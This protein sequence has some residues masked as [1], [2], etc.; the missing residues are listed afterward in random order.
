MNRIFVLPE[1]IRLA[2][3]CNL[4]TESVLIKSC[5]ISQRPR[6]SIDREALSNIYETMYI[7]WG[8]WQQ[9]G[10]RR[11]QTPW[12]RNSKKKF[13]SVLLWLVTRNSCVS[14]QDNPRAIALI[15]LRLPLDYVD[16]FLLAENPIEFQTH[17]IFF[18]TDASV[19][20]RW[21]PI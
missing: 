10:N 14:R 21:A 5:Q 6:P 12:V 19:Y 8:Y 9:I 13:P 15:E 1:I 11:F 17:I 20:L 16:Q 2:M 3:I 7:Q 4:R 18:E